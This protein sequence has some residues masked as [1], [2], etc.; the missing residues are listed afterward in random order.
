MYRMYTEEKVKMIM[1]IVDGIEDVQELER[2][3]GT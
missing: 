2:A 1:N 3:L